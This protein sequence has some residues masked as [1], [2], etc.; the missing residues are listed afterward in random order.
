MVAAFPWGPLPALPGDFA[1]GLSPGG[2]GPKLQACR[3][4]GSGLLWLSCA[5]TENT[6]GQLEEWGPRSGLR[7]NSTRWLLHAADQI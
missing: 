3:F 1:L 5:A 4:W 2:L 6:T 7:S